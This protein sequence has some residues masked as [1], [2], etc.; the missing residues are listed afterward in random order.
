VLPLT[1][2]VSAG[3][4]GQLAQSHALTDV[5]ANT[6]VHV[7]VVIVV[8]VVATIGTVLVHKQGLEVVLVAAQGNVHMGSRYRSVELVVVVVVVVLLVSNMT[9]PTMRKWLTETAALL[10]SSMPGMLLMPAATFSWRTDVEADELRAACTSATETPGMRATVARTSS[11]PRLVARLTSSGWTSLPAAFATAKLT[12]ALKECTSCWELPW[13]L[14]RSM[15]ST[16]MSTSA[17]AGDMPGVVPGGGGVG[18]GV[19]DGVGAGVGDGVGAGV[20]VG[21]GDGVGAGVGGGVGDGVGAGVGAG[22]GGGVDV[23]VMVEVL[24]LVLSVVDMAVVDVVVLVVTSA[25]IAT[26]ASTLL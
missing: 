2:L 11:G 14:S 5:L 8:V 15:F 19:G 23:V 10:A 4:V 17:S 12:A 9:S 25:M 1:G 20:G 13:R 7:V 18:V 24:V 22:V 6:I 21:V 16:Y 3:V 26:K